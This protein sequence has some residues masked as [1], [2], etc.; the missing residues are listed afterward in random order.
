MPSSQRDLRSESLRVGFALEYSLGHITHS[1]NLKRAL[2]GDSRVDPTYISLPYHDEGKTLGAWSRLPGVRSNWSLRASL[3]AYLG[4]R[5]GVAAGK[6]DSLFFHT[7][8]TSLFSSRLMYRIPSVISL[9]ATPI[10]YDALGKHYGHTVSGN[11]R[12][13]NLKKQMNIRAFAA[14]RG[15]I[16][17]SSWAKE[18]LVKDYEVPAEKVIVV[19]PGIEAEKWDF[20]AERAEQEGGAGITRPVNMLFV[21]GDFFRKGG[22]TLLDAMREMPKGARVHLN[23]VTKTDDLGTQPLP[24]RVTVHRGLTPNSDALRRLYAEADLFVFPTRADCLPLAIMEALA[25]GLP[26]VTTDIGALPEA[27]THGENGLIVPMD[28]AAAL[29]D[30]MRRLTGDAALREKLARNAR[31]TGRTKFDAT[32]NYRRL[33]ETIKSVRAI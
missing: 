11:A 23:I 5:R 13:E 31:E 1:D 12:I 16:A 6:F 14:A 24:E 33:I 21:G 18:G 17:W 4:L 27:V 29:S 25:A 3:G 26:V 32:T 7:Q 22:D 8:V 9:D 28:D 19:P 20:S 15:I 2:K 30:A 10:Q